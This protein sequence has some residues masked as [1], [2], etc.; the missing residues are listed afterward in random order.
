LSF[1]IYLNLFIKHDGVVPFS[2]LIS[3][4]TFGSTYFS[5]GKS[6]QNHCHLQ[7]SSTTIEYPIY[8]RTNFKKCSPVSNSCRWRLRVSDSN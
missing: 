7:N 3:G 1:P 6:R 4:L 5:F 8:R 2:L